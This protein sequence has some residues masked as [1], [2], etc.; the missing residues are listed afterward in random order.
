[1]C[2]Q[3]HH[4]TIGGRPYCDLLGSVAGLAIA[5][6]T[7]VDSCSHPSGAAAQRAAK[8]L[9][10]RFKYGRVKVVAGDCPVVA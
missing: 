9:R 7:G 3:T 2:K 4:I 6:D 10:P 8:A 5:K 1:M